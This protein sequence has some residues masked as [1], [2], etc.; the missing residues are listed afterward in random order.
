MRLAGLVLGIK[1]ITLLEQLYL[2]DFELCVFH[3]HPLLHVLLSL[4][5]L[6]L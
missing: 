3:S 2:G 6:P 1:F 4:F 5:L